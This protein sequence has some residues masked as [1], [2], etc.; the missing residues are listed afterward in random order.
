MK[1]NWLLRIALVV[2]VLTLGTA[3]LVSGTFAKYTTTVSGGDSARVA[4]WVFGVETDAVAYDTPAAQLVGI[5]ETANLA[6]NLADG[7]I[8]APEA[9]GDF[10]IVI[11]MTGSEVAITLTS[12]VALTNTAGVNLYFVI[13]DEITDAPLADE[14]Y[15]VAYGAFAAAL[16]AAI[17]GDIL[18]AATMEKTVYV[19]WKWIS[20]A[21]D[22]A[23]G[24]VGTDTVTLSIEITATQKVDVD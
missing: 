23:L 3:C 20:S 17:E 19:W 8:I 24:E 4:K 1:K 22:T 16:E 10:D 14:D 11:D 15:T 18:Q 6:E 2:L 9:E 7:D 21:G 5:F 13:G 12:T